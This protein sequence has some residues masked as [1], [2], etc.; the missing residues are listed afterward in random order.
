LR[1]TR[2]DDPAEPLTDKTLGEH[3][4]A[5]ARKVGISRSQQDELALASHHQLAKAYGSGFFKDLVLPYEGLDHDNGLRADVTGQRLS[6]LKGSFDPQGTIT[7]GNATRPADG[8]SV[9]LL[10]SEDWAVRQG[11]P[12]WAYLLDAESTAVNV[13]DEGESLLMA[14]A[15]AVASLL[16]RRGLKLQDFD[17]Y[18]FHEAYAAQVLAML[19]LWESDAYCRRHFGLSAPLGSVDLRRIN[20]VGGS[21]ATGHPAGATGGR[22]LGN[23]ARLLNRRGRGRGLIAIAASGGQGLAAIIER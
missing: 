9:V 13:I 17:F 15:R 5:L 11:L 6:R 4:E 10:A 16:T 21:I 8:A 18:E 7:P 1:L 20:P 22:L 3:A 14:P 2:Q 19:K 12:V 23:M